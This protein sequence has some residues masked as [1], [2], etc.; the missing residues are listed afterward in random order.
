MK[1][2]QFVFKTF[3]MSKKNANM[4]LGDYYRSLPDPKKKFVESIAKL[5]FSSENAVRRWIAEDTVPSAIKRKV[6]AEHLQIPVES[7][8][9]SKD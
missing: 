3:N 6:I 2:V 9:P 1:L 5:T 4:T 7:L 8:F